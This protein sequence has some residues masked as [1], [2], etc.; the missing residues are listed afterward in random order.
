MERGEEARGDSLL[1]K[2]PERRVVVAEAD[3]RHKNMP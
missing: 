1:E 2:L 3:I